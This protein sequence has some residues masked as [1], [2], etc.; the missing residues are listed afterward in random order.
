MCVAVAI[1]LP[2]DRKT[3]KPLPSAKWR[4]AK[5]RDRAYEPEYKVK[6]YTVK[7]VG[8]SQLF[9]VDE[10]SDWTEG[11]SI[12]EDGSFLSIVNAALNNTTDKKDGKSNKSISVGDSING[13]VLR[14]V[15]KSHDIEKAVEILI[16]N[17]IDG[18]SLITDGD[19]LFVIETTLTAE[20]KEKYRNKKKPHQR[21]EDVV[22]LDEYSTVKKE[23][24]DDYMIV[25]TNTGVFNPSFG[26]QPEDG[27]SYTSAVKRREY[28]EKA[29]DEFV[30]EPIDLF[31][32]LVKLGKDE[33]DKNPFYRPIRK[34]DEVKKFPSP[35]FSTT[36]I[37]TDPSGTMIVKPLQCKF[38]INNMENL[39]NDKYLSHLVILPQSSKMFESFSGYLLKSQIENKIN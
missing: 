15:L 19:R 6:R 38:N 3:G 27:E 39:I 30:Y 14:N 25:R 23:I 10:N 37:Q 28:A 12:H 17:K 31:S 11:V 13:R 7:E 1:K 36:I 2:R 29:M 34:F 35:I 20:V 18:A 5:I 4:L 21:F 24:K 22:P 8:A 32:T 9:L 33:V 26:Y 16:E